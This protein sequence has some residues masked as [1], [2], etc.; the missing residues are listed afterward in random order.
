MRAGSKVKGLS[1]KYNQRSQSSFKSPQKKHFHETKEVHA[2][3]ECQVIVISLLF[4]VSCFKK[5]QSPPLKF[6]NVG[7]IFW[8]KSETE[9]KDKSS[10]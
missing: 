1:I 4:Q 8:G 7:P 6:T 10:S 5:G 9:K 3:P 2:Q